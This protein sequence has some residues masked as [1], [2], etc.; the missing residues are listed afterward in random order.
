MVFFFF[1]FF[2]F[3]IPTI[4]GLG[5]GR[6][7]RAGI[8]DVAWFMIL[9]IYFTFFLSILGSESDGWVIDVCTGVAV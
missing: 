3:E 7:T 6:T 1:C 4:H 5:V 8:Y 9:I 2:L